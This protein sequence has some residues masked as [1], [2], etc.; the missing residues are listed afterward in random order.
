MGRIDFW[1]LWKDRVVRNY[2][3]WSNHILLDFKERTTETIS[4]FDNVTFSANRLQLYNSCHTVAA[5]NVISL[6]S[7]AYT[8]VTVD[9]WR[10]D[11]GQSGNVLS[12][13]QVAGNDTKKYT[14]LSYFGVLTEANK[15]NASTMLNFHIDVWTP[16]VTFKVK[17]VDFGADGA[18]KVVMIKSLK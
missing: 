11:W 13:I 3:Y 17:I 4:Y 18:T 10:A 12:D 6:F 8:N 7:N 5:T 15:I 14:D 1:F 9:T 2:K 16:N